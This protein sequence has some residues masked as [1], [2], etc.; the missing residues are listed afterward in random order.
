ML[1]ASLS[2]PPGPRSIGSLEF[3]SSV[4]RPAPPP[5]WATAPVRACQLERRAPRDTS[6]VLPA[7]SRGVASFFFTDL[8]VR[9][10][11]TAR[12][13][14]APPPG[15]TAADFRRAPPLR[16]S[17]RSFSDSSTIAR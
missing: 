8:A 13:T 3:M 4:V 7:P 11:K 14:N 6:A 17:V 12:S 15:G 2:G 1:G 9:P 10:P 5:R 16:P